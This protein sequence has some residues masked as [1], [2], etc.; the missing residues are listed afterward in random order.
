MR[1]FNSVILFVFLMALIIGCSSGGSNS[2][3]VPAAP[4][5]TPQS[6]AVITE[7][8]ENPWGTDSN[9]QQPAVPDV[10]GPDSSP[11]ADT[12]T[13]EDGY[14]VLSAGSLMIDPVTQTITDSPDR[15]PMIN[16]NV[17]GYLKAGGCP[18]GCFRYRLISVTGDVYNIDVTIENPTT[19]LAFDVR[20]IFTA[21][22]K[23]TIVNADGYTDLFD[24]A[25]TPYINPFIAF[26]T[27]YFL[28]LFPTAPG[29]I[30][31]QNLKLKWP[32]NDNGP[33]RYIV[34]ASL[35][36]NT[37][38]PYT[39]EQFQQI[40]PLWW[41]GGE[42]NLAVWVDDWQWDITSVLV[43]A[44]VF[45]NQIMYLVSNPER[46][47]TYEIHIVN[48]NNVYP[49]TYPTLFKATSPNPQ[50]ISMYNIFNVVVT[51]PIQ[52]P[53]VCDFYVQPDQINVGET[54]WLHPGTGISDPDGNAIVLYEFDYYYNDGVFNV[55]ASNT[56]GA[57][58][59][60]PP[61]PYLG[62]NPVQITMALRITDNGVPPMSKICTDI[63][64]VNSNQ[65]PVCDLTI[66]PMQI[67]S[68][69]TTQLSPG[70]NCKDPDGS[71][72]LYEYDFNYDG[73][74]FTADASNTTGAT[75]TTTAYNNPG[76]NP[77]NFTIGMRVTDNG[78]PQRKTICSKQIT[79]VA[80]QAPVC[81]L[82]V[83][84]LQIASG[85]TTT[86]SP[87]TN[88]KDPDGTIVLY[89]YDFDYNGT[90]FNVDASNTTGAPVVT[91]AYF[92]PGPGPLNVMIG[93]RV[94]DNGAPVL[95]STCTKNI[96]VVSNQS[97][98]CELI[99]SDY[100]INSGASVD[101]QPGPGTI[102]PDG[103]IVLYEYD[104]DYD[105]VTFT[106]DASNTTGA[107]VATGPIDNT[108]GNPVT[109]HIAMRVTD[110]ATT[111]IKV[112]CTKDL[113]I[114]P[115]MTANNPWRNPACQGHSQ[116]SGIC[117]G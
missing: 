104:F 12:E 15:D 13:N 41:Q 116:R 63:L 8:T 22:G 47:N 114:Q 38:E 7:L 94:T 16:I 88:C 26:G 89:E 73:T 20:L 35:P 10:P 56:T 33:L 76:P 23:K 31:T 91:T 71:I 93:M 52:N 67:K 85:Q 113:V 3:V 70:P 25:G 51:G 44:R 100:D 49:G 75:V 117:L 37:Q 32:A 4:S 112:I 61:A 87:G 9:I 108:T 110:N 39:I 14:G 72:T 83:D 60:T 97:P 28:R 36:E 84:P 106:V 68:G 55:M 111:P 95:K 69:Q 50:N 1:L 17:T 29:G 21:L 53:P 43:D 105:N 86:L 103:A 65:A 115:I 92:N 11:L 30:D 54:T 77:L 81:D 62:P 57:A 5:E 18:G 80:N 96:T 2:P 34:T 90:T 109:R 27:D 74:T 102:D 45:N 99:L 6:P 98:T 40:G 78:N 24:P 82:K 66:V 46:P 101:C 42:C 59:E 19:I 107:V 48:S 64:T 79:V 58:V